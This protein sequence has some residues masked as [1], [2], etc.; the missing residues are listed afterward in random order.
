[1]DAL[2]AQKTVSV[3]GLLSGCGS[4]LGLR[5][6]LVE[7]GFLLCLFLLL[8]FTLGLFLLFLVLSSAF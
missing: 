7:R 3:L 1:M 8:F 4:W 6:L 5:G 2:F